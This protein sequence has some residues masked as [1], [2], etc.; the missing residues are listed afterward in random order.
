VP[1]EPWIG[2]GVGGKEEGAPGRMCLS[3][4]SPRRCTLL[5]STLPTNGGDAVRVFGLPGTL[6][7]V[8]RKDWPDLGP[9]ATRRLKMIDWHLAK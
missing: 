2:K 8:A 7:R 6:L 3:Q 5:E 4:P 9:E 1:P